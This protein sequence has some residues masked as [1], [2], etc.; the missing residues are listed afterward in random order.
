MTCLAKWPA[1]NV[2][3]P[4]DRVSDYQRVKPVKI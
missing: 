4:G 3:C 2:P 1:M